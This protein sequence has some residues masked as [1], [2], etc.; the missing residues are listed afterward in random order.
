VSTGFR[1]IASA[2]SF[3]RRV[4]QEKMLPFYEL[5]VEKQTGWKLQAQQ[6]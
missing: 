5:Y 4:T 1:K 6:Q 2:E 3:R